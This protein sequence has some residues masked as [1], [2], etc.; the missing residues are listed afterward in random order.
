MVPDFWLLNS[1]SF[2]V[3]LLKKTYAY[4]NHPAVYVRRYPKIEKQKYKLLYSN[5]N[6]I[7]RWLRTKSKASK[8]STNMAFKNASHTYNV[9]T[10]FPQN[11]C[12]L[13]CH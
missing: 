3:H 5:F 13:P 10:Y 9:K 8:K 11:I 7:R 1:M 4:G 2:N 12:T 6:Y